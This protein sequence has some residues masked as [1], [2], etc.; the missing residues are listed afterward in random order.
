MSKAIRS[1]LKILWVASIPSENGLEP[2]SIFVDEND[3]GERNNRWRQIYPW[4][5]VSEDGQ[6]FENGAIELVVKPNKLFVDGD[7]W[8]QICQS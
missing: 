3:D 4:S 8:F 6:T 2:Q 7:S 5:L 1:S